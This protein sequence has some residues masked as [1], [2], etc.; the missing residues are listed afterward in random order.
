MSTLSIV[1]KTGAKIESLNNRESNLKVVENN[2]NNKPNE[3]LLL[4]Y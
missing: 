1:I 4:D 3:Y 2:N